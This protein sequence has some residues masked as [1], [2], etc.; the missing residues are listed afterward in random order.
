M[1]AGKGDA[2]VRVRQLQSVSKITIN[3]LQ[4]IPF[5]AVRRAA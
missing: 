4:G 5:E 1:G 3:E 2:A